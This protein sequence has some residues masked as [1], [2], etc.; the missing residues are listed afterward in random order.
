M[1]DKLSLE[2]F[3]RANGVQPTAKDEDI[4]SVLLSARWDN[5]EVDTALMV[6]RENR[7]NQETHVDTLHKV[8]NTDSRLNASEISSLLGIDVAVSDTDVDNINK[9]YETSNRARLIVGF[10]LSIMIAFGSIGY[11]M[12]QE[13]SGV[14]FVKHQR[15]N[16]GTLGATTT[17]STSAPTAKAPKVAQ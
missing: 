14:F 17:A 7:L 9:K 6:L 3:L 2:S 13:Q 1:I 5:N 12:Y 11:V 8:F 15:V 10:T 16:A 4:R